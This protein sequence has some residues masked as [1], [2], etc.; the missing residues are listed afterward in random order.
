M[1]S[2]YSLYQYYK[3]IESCLPFLLTPNLL[4]NPSADISNWLNEM[5]SDRRYFGEHV[6]S[7]VP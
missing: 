5:R 7:N 3:P 1:R 2:L 6:A 4:M